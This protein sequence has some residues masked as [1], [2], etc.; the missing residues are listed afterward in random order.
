MDR[1]DDADADPDDAA[2]ARRRAIAAELLRE[3]GIDYILAQ[4]V[5]IHGTPRVQ[6]RP[7]ERAR[8]VPRRQ[9]RVR[10]RGDRGHG[11]GTAQ[12]RPGRHAR[13]RHVHARALGDRRRPVRLR[14]PGRRRAVAVL[15]ADGAA[16]GDRAAGRGRLRDAGR[17]RGGAHARRPGGRTARSRRSTRSGARHAR[18]A[19][20]RL[21]GPVG[22]HALPARAD[23]GTWRGWAGSRTRPTTR[24]APPS[25]SSTG[26]T[27][28]R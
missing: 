4:W 3:D 19:L 13:P 26:S 28:T 1:R 2:P 9:R 12:P 11:P 17:R 18:Q 14:H 7:G 21:Q 16:A 5:D 20:L 15:L 27:P 10:R 6:G 8:R 25:S 23:P 24:T 22:Q